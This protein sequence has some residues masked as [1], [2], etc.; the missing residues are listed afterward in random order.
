MGTW[1]PALYSDDTACDVRDEYKGLLGDGIQEPDATQRLI[2]QWADAIADP[3]AA[4]VFWL[5]L[6]DTQWNC[7]RLQEIVKQQ[8]LEIIASGADLLRWQPDAG[9]VAK[10][11][12]VLERLEQKLA[13]PPPAPRKIRKRF[14][15]ST[16]WELGDVYSFRL[17]S[18]KSILLHVIGFHQDKGGRAPVCA[19]L[20]WV[21]AAVPGKSALEKLG[22]KS[23]PPPQR[24]SQFLFGSYASQKNYPVHR[25]NLEVKG[26]LPRPNLGGFGVI[27]WRSVDRM[28][29]LLFD[30]R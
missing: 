3:D 8:A 6:A 28:L 13:A 10:R 24:L 26:L 29:E 14:V 12:A 23:A 25:L 22:Y 1:G 9:L 17:L 15:D 27:L 20:D 11:R 2:A 16:D 18:G 5:A 19:I 21:G 30:I 4:P 7:G